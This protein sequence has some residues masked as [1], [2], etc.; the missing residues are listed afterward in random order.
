MARDKAGHEQVPFVDERARLIRGEG[1][2]RSKLSKPC[3]GDV[4]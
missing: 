1:H 2:V 4:E 3:R